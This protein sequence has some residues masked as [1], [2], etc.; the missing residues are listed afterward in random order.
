MNCTDKGIPPLV[1][2]AVN[3]ASGVVAPAL[4]VRSKSPTARKSTNHTSGRFMVV[5]PVKSNRAR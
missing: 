5:I 3:D 2:F 1:E 4:P